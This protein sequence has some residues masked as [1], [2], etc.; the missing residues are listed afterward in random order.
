MPTSPRPTSPPPTSPTTC[1]PRTAPCRSPSPSARSGSSDS[2]RMAVARG[3]DGS[4]SVTGLPLGLTQDTSTRLT[5]LTLAAS[6][7]VL[8]VLALVAWW[9]I[10][11]GLRPI[12]D[13]VRTADEIAAGDLSR[14]L[15]PAPPGTEAGHLDRGLQR[16]GPPDRVRLRRAPGVRGPPAPVRRRRLPR[17]AHAAHVDPGLHRPH[18]GGRAR[19]AR[20]P[21]RR[22]AP[23][24]GRVGAH[25]RAGRRPAA[26]W[27]ASTRAARSSAAP[28]TW[29]R[30]PP[31]PPRTPAPSTPTGR[32]R[33]SCPT[34]RSSCRAT[35]AGCARSSPTC[36]P[37][38]GST[39]RRARPVTVRVAVEGDT[40]QLVVADEGEGMAPEVATRVFERFYRADASRS[41]DRGGSGPGPLDRG[42]RVRGPRRPRRRRVGSGR[43][44]PG[45][46]RAARRLTRPS[47]STARS[48]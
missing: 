42:G 24:P 20:R 32:W 40:A 39:P 14:R 16:H 36:S 11:L 8:L 28:S 7:V 9:V 48:P 45:H 30:W 5:A 3:T 37:T 38:P 27:P 31:T 19:R 33:S 34:A 4:V 10:R 35:R 13:L 1:R 21:G 12:D 44:H 6:G 29:W 18:A 26:C 25:G 22:A 41:R 47:R 23:H 46:R 43:R 15:E 17:A 2:W